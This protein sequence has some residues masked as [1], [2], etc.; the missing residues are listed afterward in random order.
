M[1]CNKIKIKKYEK[2]THKHILKVCV[3]KQL[4]KMENC[5]NWNV[6]KAIFFREMSHLKRYFKTPITKYGTKNEMSDRDLYQ[7]HL[8]LVICM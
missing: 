5:N 8:I 1:F 3:M 7:T 2:G 4:L 6:F